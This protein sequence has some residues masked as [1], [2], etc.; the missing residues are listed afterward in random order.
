M[1]LVGLPLL[2]LIPALSPE[3]QPPYHLGDWCDLLERADTE[4][5][6]GLCDVPIR[7]YKSET[8]L[9]GIVRLLVQ[10]PTRRIIFMTHSLE[11]AQARGKRLRQLATAAGVGPA[12]GFDT[13]TNWQNEHGGG[14]V[15]MSAEQ[16]KL[17]YD[18]HCL[19]C[20]DPID[21]HGADDARVRESVDQAIAH[22]TARC[23]RRGKPGPVL[24]LMSRWHPDDP[25]GR[26]L[27]R[28]ARAWEYIH[29]PAIIDEGLP[30]ERAFAPDVWGLPELKAM[31]AELKEADPTERKWWAQLMGE[32]MPMGADL[33]GPPTFYRTMPD[34]GGYRRASGVDLAFALGDGA[35]WFA[36]VHGRVLGRKLYLVDAVRH[37]LDAH[38][39]ESTLRQD[40][41]T[42]GRSPIYSYMSG[43][44]IGTA[45]LLQEHGIP[46]V[47]MNARYSKLVRAQRTVRRWNDGD[48]LVPE[49]D[50]AP[51]VRGFLHRLRSFRGHEKDPDDEADALVSLADGSLGGTAAAQGPTT[52][53]RAYGGMNVVGGR[54]S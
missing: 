35:D 22:Y 49:E 41:S 51:W 42:Y 10:D 27:S 40:Q 29:H 43:P 33:F 37:K 31:R 44:E 9:H 2:D 21:E 3:L 1:N 28:T 30:T 46:I 13:I 53:G 32:P 50:M 8:T 24:I 6:R 47:R 12:R 26:R 15:V 20:D 36:R 45:R 19:V 34:W 18:C 52:C 23:M 48:I 11:A 14:V 25:I 38:Q 17:G 5:V 54:G 4:P 7:M 16:S 39:I